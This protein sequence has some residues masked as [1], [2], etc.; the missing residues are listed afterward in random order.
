MKTGNPAVCGSKNRS[1]GAVTV[2]YA[3][4]FPI[5][6]VCIMLLVYIG[7]LNYQQCLMQS[8]VNRYA[9]SLACYGDL[10]LMI[11]ILKPVLQK[12]FLFQ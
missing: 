5:V 4:V 10:P 6:L 7:I 8:A 1:D 12:K 11:L 3:V 2:E 9:D